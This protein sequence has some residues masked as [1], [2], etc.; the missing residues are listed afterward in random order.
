MLDVHR[1]SFMPNLQVNG[2]DERDLIFQTQRRLFYEALLRANDLFFL[3]L[4][5]T[6]HED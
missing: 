1:L 5:S 6:I 3:E 2:V 4:V